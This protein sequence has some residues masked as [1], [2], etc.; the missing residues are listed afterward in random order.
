MA[1]LF[2]H[3]FSKMRK[4]YANIN[5]REFHAAG[6][7]KALTGRTISLSGLDDHSKAR[8][9]RVDVAWRKSPVTVRFSARS[10]TNIS[11]RN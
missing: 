5:S 11:R 9:E 4:K 1:A 8:K 7:T 6:E 10:N 3:P 2:V